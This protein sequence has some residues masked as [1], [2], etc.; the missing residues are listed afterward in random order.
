VKDLGVLTRFD[1][2]FENLDFVLTCDQTP[3]LAGVT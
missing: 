2:D 3:D 1:R